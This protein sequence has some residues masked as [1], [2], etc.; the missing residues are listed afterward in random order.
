MVH[1]LVG[2]LFDPADA[3]LHGSELLL[4]A[5]EPPVVL[6]PAA[7]RILFR[8][9]HHPHVGLDERLEHLHVGVILDLV[10]FDHVINI[11]KHL[12][13]VQEPIVTF[14]LV[15][16]LPVQILGTLFPLVD[17]VNSHVVD[18]VGLSN[19]LLSNVA[20]VVFLDEDVFSYFFHLLS[21]V[22]QSLLVRLLALILKRPWVLTVPVAR[23][24]LASLVTQHTAS[25]VPGWI[26]QV[27]LVLNLVKI[28]RHLHQGDKSVV[29]GSKIVTK[30]LILPFLITNIYILWLFGCNLANSSK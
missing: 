28:S 7:L 10:V 21:V 14:E 16:P 26:F 1:Q 4:L 2:L 19:A 18:L 13:V 12:E 23:K 6:V 11:P 30:V 20:I 24:P 22:K 25:I 15:S 3:L 8:R 29:L 27:F 17:T 9:S 5:V